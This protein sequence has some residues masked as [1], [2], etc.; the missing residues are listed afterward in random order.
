MKHS[1]FEK[2]RNTKTGIRVHNAKSKKNR[3][4]VSHRQLLLITL[5]LLLLVGSSISYV[6]S[7]Y[8]GTQIGY[9]LSQLQ[10]K[11]L[12]LKELNQKLKLELRT[13]KSAQ[14]LERRARRL[15]LRQPLP[16]QTVI[17]P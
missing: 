5:I 13:L 6:W 15:G 4:R 7:S 9:S 8:E 17:L 16:E 2:K 1:E 11:E 3:L 14:I 12:E 10:Q